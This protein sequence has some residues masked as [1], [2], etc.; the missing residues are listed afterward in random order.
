M[1]A[2][3]SV[4]R[5]T[6]SNR[7][8]IV[9]AF[10]HQSL[11]AK[12]KLFVDRALHARDN[13]D[14]IEYHLWAAIALEVLGKAALAHLHPTL[15]AD[16]SHL[17]SLLTAAGRPTG[18]NHKSI[19][20]KTVFERLKSAVDAFDER[21]ERECLLMANRRNAE[22]HSG[23]TPVTGLDPRSWVPQFWRAVD[24]LVAS[25]AR[26]L[27]DWLGNDE[28]QRVR[29]ILRDAAELLRQTV[30]GRIERRRRE[31]DLRFPPGSQERSDAEA[32]SNARPIP[33][34]F[35]EAADAVEE[36]ACPACGM[37]GWMLGSVADEEVQ[38]VEADSDPEWG[39]MYSEVV[40][41]TYDVEEFRCPE[42]G[43]R[44]EGRDE[45]AVAGLPADFVREDER[46]PD[47]EPEY[48]NE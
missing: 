42:C 10:D 13:D 26:T 17:P 14:A 15:V 35:S 5:T 34:R 47:Y 27:D 30:L 19:P 29:E 40:I 12:S 38:T 8:T 4:L 7:Q 36:Q 22:L 21:M 39:P 43:L 20:A 45:V 32:R 37:K 24:V 44:V 18:T 16:P 33:P 25:Q 46:E 6:Y 28:G 1:S 3:S 2:R 23:E 11:W 9:P 31:M 41:T 48:G